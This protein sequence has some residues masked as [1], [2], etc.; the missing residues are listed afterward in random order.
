MFILFEKCPKIK[1]IVIIT[2]QDKIL[3]CMYDWINQSV[4]YKWICAVLK[5]NLFRIVII[6][7]YYP[8]N[9]RLIKKIIKEKFKK[10]I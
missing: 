6:K 4:F 3:K 5:H 9:E 8:I 10:Y 2:Q 1:S 7:C